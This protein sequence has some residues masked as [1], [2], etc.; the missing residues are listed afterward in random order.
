MAF[1]ICSGCRISEALALDRSDWNRHTVIV[2]GKGD[3]DRSVVITDRARAEVDRYLDARTDTRPAL[4]VTYSP[5]R[6][7][8]RLSVR[9]AEVIF[10]RL[11][12]R[13]PVTKLHPHRFRL[14]PAPSF[15]KNSATPCSPPTTSATTASAQSPATPKTAGPAAPK[16]A[17]PSDDAACDVRAWNAGYVGLWVADRVEHRSR[18]VMPARPLPLRG[19][20]VSAGGRRPLDGRRER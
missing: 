5:G 13:N 3:F 8:R 7:G 11:G 18:T 6:A 14:P 20:H 16:P 12:A 15:K 2:R 19:M 4:F 10:D 1:L 17:K 9:G